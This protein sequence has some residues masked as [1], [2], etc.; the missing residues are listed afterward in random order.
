MADIDADV[1][2]VLAAYSAFARGD[3]AAATAHLAPDVIWIEP[4]EFPNG[5]RHVGPEAVAAY[6]RASRKMWAALESRPEARRQGR[7]IVVRHHV[8]G[9][10]IDGT[11]HENTVADVFTIRDGRV[12]EMV[13]YADPDAVPAE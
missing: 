12:V 11:P 8:S 4:D 3:I 2:L 10:M 1:E 7:R 5:G 9:R 13:A 6:L